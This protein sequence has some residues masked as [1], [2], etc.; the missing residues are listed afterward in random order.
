[1]TKTIDD[2]YGEM[3][4]VFAQESGYLPAS[5]CD[6]A[7]RLY[8]AAAQIQSLLIQA[9]WV[10]DQSFP[11][12]AQGEYLDRLAALRGISRSIA[13][14]A[15]GNLRFGVSSAIGGDLSIAAGTTCMTP[16]GIRF[17]TT[18][19]AVLSAGSLYVDV[20]AMA[21][22][23]GKSGNVAAGTITI[24]AAMP[25]G[26]RA[27][28]NPQPF[29]GGDD[30][31]DDNSLRQRVLDSFIRLP[32]GAN[33]A[34]YEQTALSFPGV[35]AAKAVG[36]PRGIGT[37][38]VYIATD[39]GLPDEELLDA[40]RSYLQE[41]REIS[42]DLQVLAPA[43]QTV[44]IQAAV[45]CA[46]GCTFSEAKAQVEASLRAMFTG[47]LLGREVTLASLGDLLYH[48]ECIDNY[49]FSAPAADIPASATVLPRLGTLTITE[50]EA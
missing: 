5:S 4:E 33:A 27:C 14:C 31:E 16:D 36:R 21:L 44:D 28:T 19:N 18:D 49:R 38:D 35:A 47:S 39:A 8:A 32:N 37:V 11:Q 1:M 45:K 34:Y 13:T 3:L 23:P 2:I 26:I 25:A 29:S 10:L 30:A 41:R 12:T 15:T 6:L 20:P 42:V 24:M 17:A 48:L 9:Q 22:E 43:E 46:Q 40:I 7:V 50:W